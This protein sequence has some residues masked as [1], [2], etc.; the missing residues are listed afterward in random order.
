M[1]GEAFVSDT[2]I[3][4]WVMLANEALKARPDREALFYY[5]AARD[6]ADALGNRE[7]GDRLQEQIDWLAG[8]GPTGGTIESEE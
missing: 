1:D 6:A 8:I 2:R 3:T 7:T 5:V 4:G